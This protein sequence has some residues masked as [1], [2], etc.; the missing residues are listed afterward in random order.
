MSTFL[1]GIGTVQ[2][3]D[4][5]GELL[6]LK[7]LS[8]DSLEKTGVINYEHKSDFPGQLVGK[9]LKAK[10]IFSQKDCSND[11]ELHFWKKTKAPYVY[12]MAELLDDYCDS[13]KHVAGILRYDKDHKEQNSHNIMWFSIEGS[14]IPNSRIGKSVITR[15]IAR[16][17]SLTSAPCNAAAAVEILENQ[18]PKIKDD[19]EELFKSDQEAVTLFKNGEGEKL[20]ETFL[21]KKESEPTIKKKEQKLCKLHK[22]QLEKGEGPKWSG[23][24]VAGDAVH[25]SHPEH[26][27]VSIHKQ[28]SGE[29]HVKHNGRVAGIGGQ[30]GVFNNAKDAGAHAQKFMSGLSSG[31]VS[32]PAMQ[33]HPSPN[34]IGTTSIRKAVEA[35]SYNAAP[36]TLTNGAAYQTES[37]S[38]A[39]PTAEDHNFKGSKKKDWNAQA[40]S[41]YQN[42]EH[43][44][45]FEKFMKSKMPHLS[46]GEIEAFGRVIAL[47]K[48][49]ELEESLSE[50]V[51]LKKNRKI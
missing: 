30:K 47:K 21:A 45:K 8:I 1:H 32:A 50:L 24:K 37:M 7:G 38:K 6:D 48:N 43:K 42:W 27:I 46:K 4:K 20:Y 5:S 2:F 9:I 39:K 35:G 29:F 25:F 34:I 15:G 44:E 40:K 33:N 17:V 26:N 19:F 36:S 51:G 22:A 12:I 16:K 18:A 14:E 28:P 49:I 10:K 13:A 11:H 3:I 41:D 31:K 23:P